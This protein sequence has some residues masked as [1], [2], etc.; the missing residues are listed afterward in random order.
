[1]TGERVL[2][3]GI[4]AR[5]YV[6]DIRE[7]YSTKLFYCRRLARRSLRATSWRWR[8][9]EKSSLSPE[10]FFE[11]FKEQDDWRAKLSREVIMEQ[12]SHVVANMN[13]EAGMRGPIIETDMYCAEH[14]IVIAVMIR[15]LCPEV[16]CELHY[17]TAVKGGKVYSHFWVKIGGR[18]TG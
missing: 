11:K 10:R 4:L 16:D 5:L 15:E 1:M 7:N 2:A 13:D 14:A 17:G 8:L 6:R 12:F 3:K 9:R 18:V